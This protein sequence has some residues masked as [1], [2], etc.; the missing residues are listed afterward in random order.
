MFFNS[1][2]LDRKI[3]IVGTMQFWVCANGSLWEKKFLPEPF[4]LINIYE[5]N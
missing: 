3:L 4:H 2:S 5:K 1:R